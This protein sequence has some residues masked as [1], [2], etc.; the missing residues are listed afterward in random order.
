MSRVY[1]EGRSLSLCRTH[2]ATVIAARPAT[3]EELRALFVGISI[4]RGTQVERRS[5]IP[6][7]AGDDRRMLPPRPEGRRMASGRRAT[8]RDD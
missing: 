3:F 1:V 8:D 4:R 6:R 7:R 2:A 5:P